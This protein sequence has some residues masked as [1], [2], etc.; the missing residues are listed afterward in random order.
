MCVYIPIMPNNFIHK[1][2]ILDKLE[3]ISKFKV[4]FLPIL[5]PQIC[6]LCN[7]SYNNRSLCAQCLMD[8]P[9]SMPIGVNWIFAI[10]NYANPNIKKIIHNF[11]Y[12]NKKTLIRDMIEHINLKPIGISGYLS[13]HMNKYSELFEKR[14]TY[15]YIINK[16]IEFNKLEGVK[17]VILVPVPLSPDRQ[18]IR[19]YNQS[20][21]IA[22]TLLNI[23][24]K[25]KIEKDNKDNHIKEKI[26]FIKVNLLLR[27]KI[28][29]KL[30]QT[31]N[32]DERATLLND[33]FQFNNNEFENINTMDNI[34]V[35]IDDVTTT[36]STLYAARKCM[37]QNGIESKYIIAI[38]IAH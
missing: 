10:Y 33:S 14:N 17:N 32:I 29:V 13:G 35:L 34:Y 31:S 1:I 5:L 19:G 3:T 36:G 21:I 4:Y 15:F 22:N 37:I 7:K 12:Y 38:A 25:N 6:L 23:L 27:K 11:K 18:I 26:I 2:K 28:T 20:E 8:L 16:Y 24:N 30:A 9:P